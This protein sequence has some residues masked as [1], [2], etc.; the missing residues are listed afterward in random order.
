M[1]KIVSVLSVLVIGIAGVQAQAADTAGT[2]NFTL[3]EAAE[4][5]EANR[6]RNTMEKEQLTISLK[7]AV[8]DSTSVKAKT[9]RQTCGPT[10]SNKL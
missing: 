10:R 2:K 4:I 3:M 5:T 6:L 1:K 9:N 8:I 7:S